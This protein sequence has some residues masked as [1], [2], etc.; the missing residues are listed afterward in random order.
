MAS[1]GYMKYYLPKNTVTVNE[2][3]DKCKGEV[4]SDD[5]QAE[6]TKRYF[7]EK[8]GFE[9]IPIGNE[10]EL[11]TTFENLVRNYLKETNVM[12]E[13]VKYI[14]YT[15]TMT[16]TIG[17]GINIPNHIQKKFKFVNASVVEINQQ[18][19]SC[20]WTIGMASRLLANEEIGLI[21]TANMMKGFVERYKPH[22]II[23]DGV[24][25]MEVR[26]D[27]KGLEI[28]DFDFKAKQYVGEVGISNSLDMMKACA[29]NMDIVL[30]RNH[31]KK[32]EIA[33]VIHQNLSK[34]IYEIIFET[35]LGLNQEVLFWDNIK[36]TSHVGDADLIF[37]CY[38]ALKNRHIKKGSKLLF[39]AIGEVADNANYNCILL[40]V[41]Q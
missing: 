18:C 24:A 15:D 9:K 21:L 17:E 36:R 25:I 12:L 6:E 20:I 33:C 38:D 30:K 14:F 29:K 11:L 41:N 1:I 8:A 31:V 37:N 16:A 5:F 4:F 34:E 3:F 23:G 19:A 22:S 35:M 32:E 39:F 27:N 10:S 7:N 13:D 40:Q 26:N 2:F 28:L